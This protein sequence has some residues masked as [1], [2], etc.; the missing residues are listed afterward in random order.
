M[1]RTVEQPDPDSP[2]PGAAHSGAVPFDSEPA[3][4]R[5]R[6]TVLSVFDDGD[7]DDLPGYAGPG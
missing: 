2:A 5:R 3:E 7:M 4:I 6:C 1:S